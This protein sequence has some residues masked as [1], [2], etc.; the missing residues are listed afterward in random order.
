MIKKLFNK[1]PKLVILALVI[2]TASLAQGDGPRAFLLAPKG[3]WGVN[4]KWM[5]LSQNF[6]PS[7]NIL[8][9]D[10][11]IKVNVFPITAFHTFGIGKTFAQ[12]MVN[13]TPGSLSGTAFAIPGVPV[14]KVNV[15]ASGTA[16]GFL[17]LK[18]G[19]VGAPALNVMEFAKHKPSFSMM[20]Y[21]RWWYSGS[22]DE[23]KLVNMGTNR[24]TFEFGFPMAIPFGK[25]PKRATWWEVYP[26]V[27]FHTVNNS[28][29]FVTRANKSRQLPLF[30]LENHFTH[31]FTPKFWAGVDLRYQY[32]G[33]L[34]LDDV[35]Q[36]NNVNILGGGVSAGYQI[37]SMLSASA[38]YG[39]IL[40]GDNDARS[41]MFRL[42][43]VF[44]YVNMKKL[45]QPAK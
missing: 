5:N 11:D 38:S 26:A 1:K 35:K 12:I 43:L 4:P 9:K 40:A 10:A 8:V 25:N 39:G 33:A 23:N 13:V 32:G 7:G 18:V 28:P 30:L 31:N 16:D 45:K 41:D 15:N 6:T 20:G 37:L 42:S 34:E 19:L 24:S 36:D 21:F 3:I 14:S 27:R 44:V 2:T 29:S 22:Y 17:G